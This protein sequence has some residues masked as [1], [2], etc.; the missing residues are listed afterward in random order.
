MQASGVPKEE[1]AKYTFDNPSR[2]VEVR[3]EGRGS[4]EGG[5]EKGKGKYQLKEDWSLFSEEDRRHPEDCS[6]PF[7][8][9]L[10]FSYEGCGERAASG[11]RAFR[12]SQRWKQGHTLPRCPSEND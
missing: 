8:G 7:R 6:M 12:V 4:S 9:D 3:T 11:G 10:P 2:P 1:Q 5:A